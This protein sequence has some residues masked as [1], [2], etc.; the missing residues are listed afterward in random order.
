MSRNFIPAALA[1]GMGILTGY[2]TFQPAL[3]ELQIEKRKPQSYVSLFTFC[4]EPPRIA[5]R[6]ELASNEV[7]DSRVK[8]R[9]QAVGP[10]DQV[11]LSEKPD[12]GGLEEN[13]PAGA[14]TSNRIH[15]AEAS[16]SEVVQ[17]ISV[18]RQ[19]FRARSRGT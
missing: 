16:W 4:D 10:A 12:E 3:Q 5:F 2:Y 14:G 6:H 17:D 13:V 7:S 11:A 18:W 19:D 15:S 1:I 8:L 9:D